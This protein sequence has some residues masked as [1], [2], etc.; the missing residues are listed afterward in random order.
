MSNKHKM[1]HDQYMRRLSARARIVKTVGCTKCGAPI[2]QVCTG[3]RH[4]RKSVHQ[5]RLHAYHE[6]KGTYISS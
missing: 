6:L 5:E 3:V 1:T 2:D 4:D